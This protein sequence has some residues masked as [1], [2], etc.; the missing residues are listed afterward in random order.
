MREMNKA[1]TLREA[2]QE[3]TYALKEK[4]NSNILHIEIQDPQS[5]GKVKEVHDQMEIEMK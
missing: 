5:P 1:E 4:G 2:Q 3:V